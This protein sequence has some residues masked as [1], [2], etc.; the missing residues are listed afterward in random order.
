MK[1][2]SS[3]LVNDLLTAG[4]TRL[5]L[6]KLGEC[7]VPEIYKIKVDERE[8]SER[9][10]D[11][12]DG[13]LL[14]ALLMKDSSDF[15][16]HPAPYYE[17]QMIVLEIDGTHYYTFLHDLFEKSLICADEMKKISARSSKLYDYTAF[18]AEFPL[19]VAISENTS[20]DA[21]VHLHHELPILQYNSIEQ[22]AKIRTAIDELL[23]SGDENDS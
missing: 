20:G 19:N 5:T 13:L 18:A 23:N 22:R 3:E 4:F 11:K 2:H 21:D 6:A 10:Q 16:I 17:V 7:S 15:P 12:L 1:S 9:A 8:F 14:W